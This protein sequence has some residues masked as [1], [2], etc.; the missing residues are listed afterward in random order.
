MVYL[1]PETVIGVPARKESITD[2]TLL[3]CSTMNTIPL[4]WRTFSRCERNG[5]NVE[6]VTVSPDL[7]IRSYQLITLVS[8]RR[9]LSEEILN[10]R[11][12]VNFVMFIIVSGSM[13]ARGGQTSYNKY[14]I[15]GNFRALVFRGYITGIRLT[16]NP[17]LWGVYCTIYNQ[18]TRVGREPLLTLLPSDAFLSCPW[19]DLGLLP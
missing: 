9:T 12:G 19:Q 11:R 3:Q 5:R 4:V 18:Y 2:R 14:G 16:P 6:I 15:V 8:I 17:L 1:I 7:K 10:L 13:L